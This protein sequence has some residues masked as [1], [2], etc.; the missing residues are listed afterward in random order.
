[1]AGDP[2]NAT[3]W[4][5]ADVYVAPLGSTVPAGA[6]T[7]FA[8]AWELVG[9]L[10]GDAGFTQSRAEEKNDRYAWGGILVRTTRRNFKLTLAF[11]PLEDNDVTRDL[12]WPASTGGY[13]VVPRPARVLVAFEI[14]EDDRVRRLITAYQ[15]EIE[16][17]ADVNDNEQDLTRYPML[18][19][20]FPDTSVSPARLFLEQ[21]NFGVGSV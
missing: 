18:A 2:S 3:V 8:A 12:I 10:D 1:V 6:G 17:N 5:D 11:T 15:A 16:V 20:I 21:A 4:P 19:T 9:L 13:L 7:P 14:R